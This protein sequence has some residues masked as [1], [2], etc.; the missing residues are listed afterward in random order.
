MCARVFVCVHFKE[1]LKR[2]NGINGW[3]RM[4]VKKQEKRA[5]FC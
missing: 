1:A 5:T 4:Y 2:I 3:I